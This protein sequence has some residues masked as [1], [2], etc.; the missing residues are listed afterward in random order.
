LALALIFSLGAHGIMTLN[1][2]KSVVGDK[3]RNVKSIPVQLGEKRAALLACAVMN[4]AQVTAIAILFA[5]TQYIAAVIALVLLFI[6]QPM[7][8]LLIREPKERAI[9]YN[10]FGT[11]LYVLS[12]MVGAIGVR[13]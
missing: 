6:Q 9:W 13:P 10:S 12:M 4:A 1:D 11:L 8:S 2:F 7:Q 5:K 3:I